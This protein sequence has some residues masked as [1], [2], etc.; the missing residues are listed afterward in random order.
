MT[1]GKR[2]STEGFSDVLDDLRSSFSTATYSNVDLTLLQ[3]RIS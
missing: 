2:R 3:E 1:L